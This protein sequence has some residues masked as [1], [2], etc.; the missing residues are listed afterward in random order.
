[1]F[2]MLSFT[3]V[4]AK[5]SYLVNREKIVGAATEKKKVGS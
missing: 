5:A 4:I 3:T 1:M 2:E